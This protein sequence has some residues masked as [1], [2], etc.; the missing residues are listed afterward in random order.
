MKKS[1]VALMTGITGQDG[2]Y[3]AS[4]SW[5][6][7]AGTASSGALPCSHQA[8]DHLYQDPHVSI[9]AS[10]CITAT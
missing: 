4:F 1:K 3:L 8:I 10:S 5:T 7:Y 6:S 2:A 9:A